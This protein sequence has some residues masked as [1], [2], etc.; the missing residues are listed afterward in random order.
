M[1]QAARHFIK[2]PYGINVRNIKYSGRKL[3]EMSCNTI[4]EAYSPHRTMEIMLLMK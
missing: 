3:N 4:K 2:P 1:V